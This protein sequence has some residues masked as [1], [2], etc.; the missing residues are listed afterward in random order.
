MYHLFFIEKLTDCLLRSVLYVKNA[1][2][3][4]NPPALKELLV[5]KLKNLKLICS[6]VEGCPTDFQAK[7]TKTRNKGMNGVEIWMDYM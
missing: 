5:S 4:E 7:E 3:Q 2:I 6:W 1:K